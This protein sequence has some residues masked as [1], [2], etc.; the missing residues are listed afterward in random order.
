[1]RQIRG[2]DIAMIFQDPM[3]TL[4]PAFVVGEQIRESLRIHNLVPGAHGASCGVSTTLG[5]APLST[6]GSGTQWRRGHLPPRRER[7]QLSA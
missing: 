1:M 2:K 7:P 6:G 5:V 4:N 3:T